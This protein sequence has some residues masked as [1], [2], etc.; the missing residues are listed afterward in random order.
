M[1]QWFESEAADNVIL[2]TDQNCFSVQHWK[3]HGFIISL[4]HTGSP[5]YLVLLLTKIDVPWISYFSSPHW[6]SHGITISLD[7]IGRPMDLILIL[8]TLEV[9][10]I[11]YF[12]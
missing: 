3:S 9:P 4:D 7:H 2:V 11:S 5:M 8:T 12:S 10:W 1:L 6:K